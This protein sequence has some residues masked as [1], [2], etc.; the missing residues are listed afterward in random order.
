MTLMINTFFGVFALTFGARRLFRWIWDFCLSKGPD[1]TDL[2]VV[3]EVN[4]DRRTLQ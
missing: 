2:L 4:A 3:R 1:R